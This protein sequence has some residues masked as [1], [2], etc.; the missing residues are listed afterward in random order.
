MLLCDILMRVKNIICI[1][2]IFNEVIN[3]PA[4]S[5]WC[6]HA[7]VSRWSHSPRP[8]SPIFS[9]PFGSL[10]LSEHTEPRR[11]S[12]TAFYIHL[13]IINLLYLLF[14]C[15]QIYGECLLQCNQVRCDTEQCDA[16]YDDLLCDATPRHATPRHAT[17]RHA[18]PR[19]AMP[20]HAMPW[21]FMRCDAMGNDR[22]R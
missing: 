12:N 2:I 7:I 19:H 5:E 6:V 10:L 13:S 1:I 11:H 17:P 3:S 21:P 4:T 14:Y 20:R 18:T 22:I 16:I 9:V 15:M 8:S